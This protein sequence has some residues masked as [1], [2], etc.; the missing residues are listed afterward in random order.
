MMSYIGGDL[1]GDGARGLISP[2]LEN[3]ITELI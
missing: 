2:P 1:Q 3:Q